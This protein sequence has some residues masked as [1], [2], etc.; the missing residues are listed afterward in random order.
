MEHFLEQLLIT[1]A[2]QI[3]IVKFTIVLNLEWNKHE[4]S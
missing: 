4:Y 1:I 3:L 2:F